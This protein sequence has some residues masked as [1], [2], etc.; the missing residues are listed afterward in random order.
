[1]RQRDIVLVRQIFFAWL[2]SLFNIITREKNKNRRTGKNTKIRGLAAAIGE[3]GNNAFD[4]NFNF[5]QTFERGVYFEPQFLG[6]Y[7]VIV[8]FRKIPRAA[9]QRLEV[10]A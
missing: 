2:F 4:H 10:R 7:T 5:N 9:R 6:S 8:N 1:M 3:L